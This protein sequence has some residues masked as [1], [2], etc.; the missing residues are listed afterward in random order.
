MQ[1]I[2]RLARA[3]RAAARHAADLIVL[4]YRIF[5]AAR[6]MRA[7]RCKRDE[8]AAQERLLRLVAERFEKMERAGDLA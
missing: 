5:L 7:A 3:V 6:E 4:D 8:R 1:H 2:E